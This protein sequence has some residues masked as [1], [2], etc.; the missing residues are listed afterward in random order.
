[1]PED[2]QIWLRERKLTLL[3]QAATL[4]NDYALARTKSG[5]KPITYTN[6]TRQQENAA[7]SDQ[8]Q[9]QTQ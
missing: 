2:L 1:M 7:V 6:A 8:G 9:L 3:R 4:A 5:N